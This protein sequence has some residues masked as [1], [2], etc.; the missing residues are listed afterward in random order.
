MHNIF[1]PAVFANILGVTRINLPLIILLDL[2]RSILRHLYV[3]TVYIYP[4]LSIK[5]PLCAILACA[6]VTSLHDYIALKIL[7]TLA[8]KL[9][10]SSEI[11]RVPQP[12]AQ[13]RMSYGDIATCNGG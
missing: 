8:L 11:P 7:K 4:I 12:S 10:C 13:R 1:D 5:F 3:H 2:N 9:P 6:T